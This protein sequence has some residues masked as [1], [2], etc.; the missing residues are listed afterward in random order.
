MKIESL[1]ARIASADYTVDADA[2]AEALIR[3]I[4][5][6]RTSPAQPPVSRRGARTRGP[7]G[8]RPPR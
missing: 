4:G 8:S 7:R 5:E 2:V 6:R 3:R 1:K